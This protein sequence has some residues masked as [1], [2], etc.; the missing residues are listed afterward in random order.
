MK[1]EIGSD[2]ERVQWQWPASKPLVDGLGGGL[3]EVRTKFERIQYRVLFCIVEG[4]MVL[5]HGFVKKARTEPDD[6]ALGSSLSSFLE[7]EGIREDVDLRA[8][9][10]IL[11][12]QMHAKMQRDGVTVAALARRMNTSRTVAIRLLD[13]NDM[14]FT[15]T[16]LARASKAL[17]MNLQ[18]T[19]AE[20]RHARR[21]A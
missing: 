20:R 1:K 19:L 17:G 13:P 3:H 10:K 16:T 7:E 14:G 8:N 2:I 9:K 15:F 21:R 12:D 5:L 6:V 11:S 4:T 18:V